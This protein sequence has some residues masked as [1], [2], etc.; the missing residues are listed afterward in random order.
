M[1]Q[2][3]GVANL[4]GGALPVAVRGNLAEAGKS[5]FKI[6]NGASPEMQFMKNVNRFNEFKSGFQEGMTTNKFNKW[7]G[8]DW[9]QNQ[10]NKLA[11]STG[12]GTAKSLFQELKANPTNSNVAWM[13]KDLVLEDPKVLLKQGA[14]TDKQLKRAAT[15]MVDITQ[16]VVHNEKL[17]YLWVRSGLGTVPQIFQRIAF[18]TTKAMK[19]G[20]QQAP[21]SSIAKLGT[22]G[23]ALGEGIAAIKEVPKTAGQVGINTAQQALGI[24]KED[25][26]FV[27]TFKENMGYGKSGTDASRFY[28]TKRWLT[29]LNKEAGDND[30]LVHSINALENSFA[31]GMPLTLLSAFAGAL[32]KDSKDPGGDAM[33]NLFVAIDEGG[34]LLK[35]GVDT[36]TQ[37]VK[38]AFGGTPDFRDTARFVTRRLPIPGGVQSGVI[39][40]IDSSKQANRPV[41]NKRSLFVK[42]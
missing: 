35:Q 37:I 8:I 18:Q 21:V 13:L 29:A 40:E 41:R 34:N 7:Y 31:G 11:G 19:D 12:L 23:L 32:S 10:V 22:F 16:G 27:P 5:L 24:T 14:L 28:N 3:S 25:K 9:T 36:A 2:L 17:P 1:M 42:F 6:F 38:P 4:F 33:S 26:D 39:R 20:I 15:R 30:T